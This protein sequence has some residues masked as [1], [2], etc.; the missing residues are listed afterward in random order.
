MSPELSSAF[1]NALRLIEAHLR[2]TPTPTR[3]HDNKIICS[4]CGGVFG[5]FKEYAPKLEHWDL[6]CPDCGQICSK[7]NKILRKQED[8]SWKAR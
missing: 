7:P 1:L 6:E 2:N 8:E 5:D 4:I 3:N